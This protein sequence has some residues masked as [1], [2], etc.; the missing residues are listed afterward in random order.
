MKAFCVGLAN[1]AV[2][3][4]PRDGGKASPWKSF[5]ATARTA[6]LSEV[7]DENAWLREGTA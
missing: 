3:L 2:D 6:Y 1:Q 5:V 4:D 7:L